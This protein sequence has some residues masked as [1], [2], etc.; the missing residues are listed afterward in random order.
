MG[1]HRT[2]TALLEKV[3]HILTQIESQHPE[4][5]Q[6]LDESHQRMSWQDNDV[7][8]KAMQEYLDSLQQQWLHY[9]EMHLK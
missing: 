7:D 6:F 9:Q 3:A 4:L 1:L 5:Y 2:N 8:D